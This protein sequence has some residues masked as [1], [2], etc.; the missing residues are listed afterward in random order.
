MDLTEELKSM[1]IYSTFNKIEAIKI[2]GKDGKH[3][4][5]GKKLQ[6]I[7]YFSNI[8][9]NSEDGIRKISTEDGGLNFISDH[10]YQY[11]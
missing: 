10:K 8:S 11:V 9:I 1:E 3:S 7:E 4:I 5:V 2:N 6:N